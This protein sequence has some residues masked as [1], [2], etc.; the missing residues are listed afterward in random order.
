MAKVVR[1]TWRMSLPM[2][3]GQALVHPVAPRQL[4]GLPLAFTQNSLLTPEEFTKRA[5]ERGVNLRIEHLLELHRRRALI[6]L[7][8]ITQRPPKSS[9]T[10]PV[11]ASAVDGYGQYRSPIALITT[12]A[13]HGLLVDPATAPFRPWDG[14]LPLRT[15]YGVHRYP[16]VF[17]SPYQL[18]VLRKIDQLVRSMSGSRVAD[19][20]VKF[21][22]G[23]LTRDEIAVLDGGRQLAILLSALD[24]HYLPRITLTASHASEW[25][26]EDPIFDIASR[27]EIFGFKPENLAATAEALLSQAKFI[28]P[29]GEFYELIRQAHP[30][31]WVGLRRDA[32]QAMD[33]RIAAEIILRALDDLG[34]T[35]LSMRPP[36]KGRM[37]E[38]AIDDRLQAE[39]EQLE[40]ILASR[41]LSPRPAVLLVL[42]GDTEMLLM[43]RVLAEFYGKPVPPTLIE[44]VNMETVTRDL[45]LLV[46]H[47][48]GPRLGDDMGNNMVRLVRPPTRILVAVDPEGKYAGRNGPRKERDKLVS[49]LH[50]SLPVGTRSKT[51]LSQLRSLVDVVTWGTVP[52]EFANFTNTELAKAIIRCSTVPA[53][54]TQRDLVNALE[55]ERTIKKTNPNIRRS[56]NVEIICKGWPTCAKFHKTELAEE[57]WPV[58]REKTLRDMASGKPLRVPAVRVAAKAF[59]MAA[60]SPRRR[61][62]LRVLLRLRYFLE[63]LATGTYSSPSYGELTAAF[64][65]GKPP[66]LSVSSASPKTLSMTVAPP[67]MAGTITCR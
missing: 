64:F 2:P 20:R 52:W 47:E 35:D 48:A 45:D 13:A 6:P 36:R 21:N 40:D 67:R 16:S 10:V 30:S 51:S 15:Q 46:R 54:I 60:E 1:W 58:L 7:L 29:L 57:L 22:L 55:S 11:A 63:H 56:P 61:V 50:G 34:R 31:T 9:M 39:P 28:D 53:G 65:P 12:A 43:P 17:Y 23:K 44:P 41:G 49:R 38:A 26:K 32:L 18:L 42:E 59:R 24:M 14:G 62:A 25:E 4:L 66:R 33:Y 8:R 19:G 5:D 27:L 37:Y 3:W